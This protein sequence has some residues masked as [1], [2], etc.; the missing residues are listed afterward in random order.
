MNGS[1]PKEITAPKST[2]AGHGKAM[3]DPRGFFTMMPQCEQLEEQSTGPWT[4]SANNTSH[5]A[6]ALSNSCCSR[7]A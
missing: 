3:Q 4:A 5:Q 2:I 1:K 7:G 6:H